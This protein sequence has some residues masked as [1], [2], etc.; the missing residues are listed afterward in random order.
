MSVEKL[1][2]KVLENAKRQAEETL[3]YIVPIGEGLG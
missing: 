1:T 2:Q 3:E